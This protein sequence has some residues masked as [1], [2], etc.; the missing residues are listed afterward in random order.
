MFVIVVVG[1]GGVVFGGICKDGEFVLN[2]YGEIVYKYSIY[3][4]LFLCY[5]GFYWCFMLGFYSVVF[6]FIVIFDDFVFV[7]YLWWVCLFLGFVFVIGV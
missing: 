4:C 2:V 7:V 1:V 5:V 3:G 6:V